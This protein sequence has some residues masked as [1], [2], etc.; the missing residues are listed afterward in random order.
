MVPKRDTPVLTGGQEF[1]MRNRRRKRSVSMLKPDLRRDRPKSSGHPRS[2]S[3]NLCFKFQFG[4]T[5][6]PLS[7]RTRSVVTVDRP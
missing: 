1:I 7:F 6:T 4:P 3:C 5:N 2:M